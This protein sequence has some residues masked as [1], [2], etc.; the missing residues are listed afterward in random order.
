MTCALT[1][2][3]AREIRGQAAGLVVLSFP[4]TELKATAFATNTH[5]PITLAQEPEKETHGRVSGPISTRRL[6]YYTA[7]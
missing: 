4:G 1:S 7:T 3:T 6:T 2:H 5:H